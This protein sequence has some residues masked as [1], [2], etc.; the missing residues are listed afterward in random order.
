MKLNNA[1]MMEWSSSVLARRNDDWRHDERVLTGVWGLIAVC[2]G[3][4]ADMVW[5]VGMI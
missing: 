1:V 4:G 2:L 5:G 3:V